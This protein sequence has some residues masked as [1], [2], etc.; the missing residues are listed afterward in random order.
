MM[1]LKRIR[2]LVV[3]TSV[4]VFVAACTRAKPEP[5][6]TTVPSLPG[7]TTGAQATQTAAVAPVLGA[8]STPTV[9]SP[10]VPTPPETASPPQACELVAAGSIKAYQRPSLEGQRF[11]T[12]QPGTRVMVE[13]M[14]SDGWF[15]F[16]P[17]YAQAGNVGVFRLRWVRHGG[18]FSLHGACDSLPVVQGPPAEVCFTMAVMDVPV[19]AA[20]STA[21]VVLSKLDVG[22]YAKVL[23]AADNWLLVD[24][25]VGSAGVEAHGWIAAEQASF[26]GR[27]EDLPR[28]TP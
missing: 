10:A 15:G 11:A 18:A 20:P 22:G 16:D 13:A 26:N 3:A 1:H 27:C 7:P 2:M 28:V 6:A 4:L 12:L 14:T 17:G 5:V 24:L 19:Y 8:E 25:S 21:S 23:G 9:Q